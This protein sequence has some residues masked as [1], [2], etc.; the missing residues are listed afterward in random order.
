M[1][2]SGKCIYKHFGKLTKKD[3]DEVIVLIKKYMADTTH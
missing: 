2:K 3:N 1:D